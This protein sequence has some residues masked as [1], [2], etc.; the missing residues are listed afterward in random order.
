MGTR[1]HELILHIAKKS[2]SDPHFGLTKLHKIL[3]DA[4]F[5]FYREHGRSITNEAYQK[6]DFG[7]AVCSLMPTIQAAE[8]DKDLQ[9]ERENGQYAHRRVLAYRQA[10]LSSFSESEIAAVNKAIDKLAGMN[11][12]KVS[13][14]S[15]EFIGWQ[16]AAIRE[17]IP[18]ETVYLSQEPLTQ[19]EM[20]MALESRL[21]I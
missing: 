1:L 14:L 19:E 5:S 11:A 15:H 18:Y 3:F 4:D 12:K 16:L 17:I 20:D 7:P 21:A 10:D 9:L 6:L 13:N 2:E 8:K